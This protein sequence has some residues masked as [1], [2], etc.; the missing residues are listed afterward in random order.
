MQWSLKLNT[1]FSPIFEKILKSNKLNQ[2]PIFIIATQTC[3]ETVLHLLLNY[4]NP[5]TVIF[6]TKYI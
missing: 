3:Q 4:P 6:Q 2:F 1:I 5:I